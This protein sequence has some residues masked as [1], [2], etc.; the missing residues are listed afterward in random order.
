[1]YA[2]TPGTRAGPFAR[3]P[4]PPDAAHHLARHAACP[5]CINV[6]CTP[7]VVAVNPVPTGESNQGIVSENAKII[8]KKQQM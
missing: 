6:L 3:G 7:R 2:A 1:M 8:H 5:P 4:V